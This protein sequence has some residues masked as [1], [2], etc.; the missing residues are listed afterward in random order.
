MK[1]ALV[2]ED[3][4]P[5]AVLERATRGR[6]DLE[7]GG[8]PTEE[9]LIAALDGKDVLFATSRLPVTGRVIDATDL[10]LIAKIGT[11]IDN[12]D[13]AAAREA[14]VPVT[15]TPGIN[16]QPVAEHTVGLAIAVAR[17]IVGNHGR[18]AEG[19]WRDEATLGTGVVGKSVGIVGFGRIGRRVAGLLAGFNVDVL[20]HDPY[21]LK[22]DTDVTGAELT[23]LDDLL[24]RS[25]VVTINAELT[26]ETRGLIGRP[27]FDRMKD[28]AVLV[29]TARG[30]IVSEPALVDALEAGEIAGA[31][32][33]VFETEPLP[34]SS[35]LH[36]LDA[37]VATP[38]VAAMT[39]ECR[40]ESI[41][42]LASNA[43][44]LLA[45]ERV[46]DRFLAV[47]PDG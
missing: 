3:I 19:H 30:P 6:I 44:G 35:R 24:D 25:D 21:V 36:E 27:E 2:D 18:L 20:A 43:L 17:D 45:G 38:H 4:R 34:A 15:Y 10:D 47:E 29:N 1:Y 14:A 7:F 41:E 28:S 32:L 9:A 26:D 31:G 22:Q 5:A 33:D 16:A 39:R 42:T 40:V 13:L 23:G 46:P 8:E 11:G 12:V 37:V